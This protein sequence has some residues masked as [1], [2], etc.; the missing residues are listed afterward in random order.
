[1]EILK[2]IYDNWVVSIIFL[3]AFYEIISLICNSVV[4][5]VQIKYGGKDKKKAEEPIVTNTRNAP[6][7][8]PRPSP[9]PTPPKTTKKSISL[10]KETDLAKNISEKLEKPENKSADYFQKALTE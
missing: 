4:K 7:K 9:G 8:K 6:T 5:S 1:M 10:E 2:F 3:F